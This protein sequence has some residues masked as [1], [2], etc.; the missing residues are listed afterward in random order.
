MS[1]EI[2]WMDVVDEDDRVIAVAT[3]SFIHSYHLMHRGVHILVLN[4]SGDVLVQWRSTMATNYPGLADCSAGGQVARG[5]TYED[6]AK[7]ELKEELGCRATP[8]YLLHY[9][10]FSV[11]QREKR[12]VFVHICEG[13]FDLTDPA[14]DSVEW[15]PMRSVEELIGIE[16]MTHGFHNTLR[17]ARQIQEFGG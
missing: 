3:R 6:A 13:P 1:D 17:L 9:D 11:R 14:V 15:L 4:S 8:D 16:R 12:A 2:E 7:R 10:A 5:E